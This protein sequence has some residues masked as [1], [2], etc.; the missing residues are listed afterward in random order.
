M[1]DPPPAVGARNATLAEK[2][3]AVATMAVGAPGTVLRAG[4]ALRVGVAPHEERRRTAARTATGTTGLRTRFLADPST[5]TIGNSATN[6]FAG[7]GD[8]VDNVPMEI[9]LTALSLDGPGG[10][11]T[12]LLTIAPQLE[13][14]GHEVTLYAPQLGTMADVACSRGLRVARSERELPDLCDAVIAQDGVTML[15]MADRYPG[16]VRVIVVHSAEYDIHLPP[17]IDGTVS[18]AVVMSSAVER[19]VRAMSTK[20]KVER[21]RQPIDLERHPAVGSISDR[22]RRVLMLGNYLNGRARDALVGVCENAGLAWRHVGIHGELLPD[23]ISAISD[24]DIVI[25]QGRSALDAMACGRA[26]WV[27][28]PVAADGWVTAST[29]AS[30]EADGFRGRATDRLHDAESFGRALRE[31][32]PSMGTV[33]RNLITLNHSAYE[34]A[35]ELVTIIDTAPAGHKVDAP[36][37]EL[38]RAVRAQHD[39]QSSLE[40]I[41][42][43][44]RALDERVTT[45]QREIAVLERRLQTVVGSRRW[46]AASL[47]LRPVDVARLKRRGK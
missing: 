26:A 22:P 29:Y 42:R 12:Y 34:H 35:I 17:G 41:T 21:L 15:A 25:G 7:L 2:L 30:F 10:M 11:Q 9:V 38:A 31:Y 46:R 18:C 27:Y 14:L 43:E 13:R 6:R 32:D 39:A 1:A 19:R 5:H 8:H 37:R 45:A 33:N 24:A 20:L 44:L 3:S 36:L 40:A 28:G 47:A 16:A 4:L 23:P